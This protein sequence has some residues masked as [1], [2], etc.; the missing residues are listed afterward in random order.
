[1]FPS[2]VAGAE[3]TSCTSANFS[4]LQKYWDIMATRR[5]ARGIMDGERSISA[6]MAIG[7]ACGITPQY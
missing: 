5:R 6:R 1:L 3:K 4:D 7:Q 2:A